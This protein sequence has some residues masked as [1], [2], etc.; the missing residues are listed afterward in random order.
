MIPKITWRGD[1]KPKKYT[2]NKDKFFILAYDELPSTMTDENHL[3]AQI[4][5]MIDLRVGAVDGFT[6]NY[7]YEKKEWK[8]MP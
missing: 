8:K 4:Q 3:R 6:S 7:D 1:T 5:R 2:L